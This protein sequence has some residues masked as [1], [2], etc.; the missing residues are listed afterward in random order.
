MAS[1]RA[2]VSVPLQR[3]MVTILEG[4]CAALLVR[5][6]ELNVLFA[7]FL[8]IADGM[9]K[10]LFE[11]EARK[12]LLVKQ[13]RLLSQYVPV[14]KSECAIVTCDAFPFIARPGNEHDG[15]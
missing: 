1:N 3:R 13:P 12:R 11:S 8:A 9:V 10:Q 2:G 5:G 7:V 6:E 15:K 14:R 4:R